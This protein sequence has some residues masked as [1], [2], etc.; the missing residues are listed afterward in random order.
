VGSQ[1][2]SYRRKNL[3]ADRVRRLDELGFLW[4]PQDTTWIERFDELVA[5][6][7]RFDDCA[8]PVKWTENPDLGKWVQGQRRL[9]KNSGVSDGRFKLLNDLGFI[10]NPLDAQWE[11]M[12]AELVSYKHRF[13]N[14]NV[15]AQWKENPKFGNWVLHQR[16]RHR[17]GKLEID[18]IRRLN[19]LGF[20]WSPLDAAWEERFDELVAYKKRFGDC[21]VPVKWAE[22]LKLGSWVSNQRTHHRVGNLSDDRIRRLSDLGFV[23]K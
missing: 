15:P 19:E 13:N 1:R 7:K 8:V 20:V 5:Y 9:R 6:K 14:C 10:W 12:Y 11:E 21:A 16:S 22:N 17:K 18:R 4:N 3:S 2:I 23:W